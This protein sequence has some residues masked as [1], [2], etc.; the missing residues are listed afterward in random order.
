MILGHSLF[1]KHS[2]TFSIVWKS[3]PH[4]VEKFPYALEMLQK[5]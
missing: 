1:G 5:F 2:L 4:S 3:Y